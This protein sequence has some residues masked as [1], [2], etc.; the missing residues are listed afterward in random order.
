MRASSHQINR[1]LPNQF[2]RFF[3][4]SIVNLLIDLFFITLMVKLIKIPKLLPQ[5]MIF[6]SNVSNGEFISR[7]IAYLFTFFIAYFLQSRLTFNEKQ[8]KG[9]QIAKYFV[10]TSG[11]TLIQLVAFPLFLNIM[12]AAFANYNPT[13]IFFFYIS[14]A[15]ASLISVIFSFLLNKFWTFRR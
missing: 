3:G 14:V 4:V 15:L 6:F 2:I 13:S 5:K 10:V 12:K 1:L 7:L 11:L 9:D 8:F